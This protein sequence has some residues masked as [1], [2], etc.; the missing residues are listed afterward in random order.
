MNQSSMKKK[1]KELVDFVS[2]KFIYPAQKL[3]K[4]Q[5]KR[6]KRENN[7]N[8]KLKTKRKESFFVLRTFKGDNSTLTQTSCLSLFIITF[9]LFKHIFCLRFILAHSF[10]DSQKRIFLFLFLFRHSSLRES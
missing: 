10:S 2:V 8:E 1:V 4:R 5:R 3:Y 9:F 6:L 7:D